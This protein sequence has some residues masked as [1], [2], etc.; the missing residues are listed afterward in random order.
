MC[1]CAGGIAGRRRVLECGGAEAL[2]RALDRPGDVNSEVA[3]EASG[4]LKNLAAEPRSGDEPAAA[5][6]CLQG[7]VLHSARRGRRQAA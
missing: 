4:A 1:A 2:L 5:G 7:G 6:A 3:R